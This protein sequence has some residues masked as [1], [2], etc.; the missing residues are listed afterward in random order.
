MRWRS[1]VEVGH[2]RLAFCPLCA[3]SWWLEGQ[4]GYF[5]RSA[6]LL[7]LLLMKAVG[8]TLMRS[9]CFGHVCLH[10]E[11]AWQ[12]PSLGV[13]QD[14]QTSAMRRASI[15]EPHLP[16]CIFSETASTECHLFRVT[17]SRR[18]LGHACCQALRSAGLALSGSQG[19]ARRIVGGL[20][21]VADEEIVFLSVLQRVTTHGIVDRKYTLSLVEHLARLWANSFA[22]RARAMD[23]VQSVRRWMATFPADFL[24]LT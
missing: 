23:P 2:Q 14:P 5:S 4:N 11:G 22:A 6:T 16:E 12:Q 9:P 7:L 20:L 24:Y 21:G 19:L 18:R 17:I 3:Y 15:A 1:P 10:F 13:Y 8:S